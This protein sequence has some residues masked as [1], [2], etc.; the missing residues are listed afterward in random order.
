MPGAGP[1]TLADIETARAA[2]AATIVRTPVFTSRWLSAELGA[3]VVLKAEILQRTGSFKTRGAVNKIA[4][5]GEAARSGVVCA[6]AGNHAQAVALAAQAAGVSCEVFMPKDASIGKT[7]A[8]RHYG[9]TV[10]LGGANLDEAIEMARA[11]ADDTG[12]VFVHPFDDP[13]IIAGAGTLGVEL[14]ED[15]PDCDCVVVPLGGGGLTSGLA[16]AVKSLKPG[17]RV[18]AVQAATCAPYPLSI[19]AGAPVPIEGPVITLADGI[20]VKRPGEIT[21]PMV[22]EYVDEVVTVSEDEIAQAMVLLLERAKLVVEG[23]GAVGVAAVLA[24][25]IGVPA[26]ARSGAPAGGPGGKTAVVLSGG[27]VDIGT[28]AP[29]IRLRETIAGRRLILFSVFPDRPGE[30]AKLLE[31]IGGT[32]ANLVEVDHLREGFDLH[33]RET[34][35][36]LTLETRDREHAEKVIETARLAG[37]LVRRMGS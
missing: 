14:I 30:L 27:N 13:A 12:R 17:T 24:G 9:A 8:T 6:S 35:V 19:A 1:V 36:H 2:I 33:V 32:G 21:L 4:S 31:V 5:L 22:G 7:E 18:I 3:P 25:R 29:A 23:A 11:F 15:V 37:Y 20:A 16:V 10:R 26:G 28:L 34:G